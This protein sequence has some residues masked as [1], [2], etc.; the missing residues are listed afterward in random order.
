[1]R[2]WLSRQRDAGQ[3]VPTLERMEISALL[4]G[5]LVYVLALGFELDHRDLQPYNRGDAVVG[6]AL[7]A[8][9]VRRSC[10]GRAGR[11]GIQRLIGHGL[12]IEEA[13]RLDLMGVVCND[14]EMHPNGGQVPDSSAI[15]LQL[16]VLPMYVWHR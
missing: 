8:S 6:E 10:G 15:D 16:A 2:T 12:P 11:A 5:C 14:Y 13:A 4:K 3:T 7:R 1:M 9:V